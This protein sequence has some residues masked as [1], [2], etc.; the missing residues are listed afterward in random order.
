MPHVALADDDDRYSCKDKLEAVSEKI[1]ILEGLV[2]T[3]Q[4][5]VD[6]STSNIGVNTTDLYQFR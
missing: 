6:T 2:T 5:L 3:R 1:A 4:G